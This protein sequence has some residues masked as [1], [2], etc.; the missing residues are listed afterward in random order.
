M[1]TGEHPVFLPVKHESQ[2][3]QREADHDPRD[4]LQPTA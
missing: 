3:S 4:D 1:S 2:Q